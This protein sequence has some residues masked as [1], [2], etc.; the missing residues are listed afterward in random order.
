MTQMTQP[1]M[2]QTALPEPRSAGPG[3]P[4]EFDLAQVLDRA[5][6]VFREKG[7]NAASIGDL[8]AATK[9]SSGSLY[10]AFKGKQGIFLA[11]LARYVSGRDAVL[12]ARLSEA[13]SGRAELRAF[14]SVYVEASQG[15]EGRTGCMVVAALAEIT[16]FDPALSEPVRQAYGR[17]EARILGIFAR[18]QADGTLRVCGDPVTRARL[19]LYTLQGMRLAGKVGCAEAGTAHLVDEVLQLFD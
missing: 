9:L 6:L 13:P 2:T 17:L 3:R 18:G 4:R 5:V 19:L 14:I 10:K 15:A 11:A 8:C 12:A 1:R 7:Y 16:T